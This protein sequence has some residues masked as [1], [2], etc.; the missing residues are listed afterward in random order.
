MATREA[1]EGGWKTHSS[2][3][4]QIQSLCVQSRAASVIRLSAW[5]SDCGTSVNPDHRE[6]PAPAPFLSSPSLPPSLSETGW[7]NAP[8]VSLTCPF[9]L[10][11]GLIKA[12]KRLFSFDP[13]QTNSSHT[14]ISFFT[15]TVTCSAQHLSKVK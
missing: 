12:P 8:L 15:A 14:S 1:V 11:K 6:R 3:S 10:V 7:R 5:S 13:H 2:I 9:D 4:H